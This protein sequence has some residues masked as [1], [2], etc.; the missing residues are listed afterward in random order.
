MCFN[1]SKRSHSK[2]QLDDFTISNSE[3]TTILNQLSFINKLFGTNSSIINGVKQLLSP[4]QNINILD[5]G[6]GGGDVTNALS[7]WALKYNFN[8][9][10]KGIDANQNS[11]NIANTKYRSENLSFECQNISDLNI[12][13]ELITSSNFIYHLTDD[14]LVEFLKKSIIKTNHGIVFCE[15]ERSKIAV[16]LFNIFCRL[17]F[18]HKI[19]RKDGITA[20][21]RAFTYHELKKI[22][23]KAG[24]KNY[25]LK[26]VPLFRLQLVI[27]KN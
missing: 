12:Q 26:R 27:F 25:Q 14:E 10:I 21:K 22:V 18:M 9:K 4:N 15:L 1:Y 7:S 5:L 24:I 17:L 20:I 13:D 6:S 3:L 16:L 11:V 23:E 2:E 8:L 19:I